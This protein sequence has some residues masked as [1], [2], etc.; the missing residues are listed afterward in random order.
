MTGV[1]RLVRRV[2]TWAVLLLMFAP[3]WVQTFFLSSEYPPSTER[4]EIARVTL[5]VSVVACGVGVF[6]PALVVPA[7]VLLALWTAVCVTRLAC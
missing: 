5:A 3:F 1:R 6:R 2:P 7:W 4:Q